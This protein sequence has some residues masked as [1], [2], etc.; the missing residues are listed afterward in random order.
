M[1]ACAASSPRR[2]SGELRTR[3]TASPRAPRPK[4]ANPYLPSPSP[5][6]SRAAAV[7]PSSPSPVAAA[8]PPQPPPSRSNPAADFLTSGRNR[9]SR[10]LYRK[11]ADSPVP[12]R[13]RA[14]PAA[15]GAPSLP[16]CA[17]GV[18]T[19]SRGATTFPGAPFRPSPAAPP[20]HHAGAAT[21]SPTPASPSALWPK[22]RRGRN[23]FG[24]QGPTCHWLDPLSLAGK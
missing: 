10:H 15:L 16:P 19:A 6:P 9:C 8:G 21:A 1:A 24:S 20:P 5:S 7:P 3:G 22:N 4:E 14:P 12:P 13:A 23:R 18:A 17:S 2:R 11:A